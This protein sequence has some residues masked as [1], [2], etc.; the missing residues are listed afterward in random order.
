MN[1]TGRN[2]NFGI[3][4]GNYNFTSKGR[5]LN[6]VRLSPNYSMTCGDHGVDTSRKLPFLKLY[7]Q[8]SKF[9]FKIFYSCTYC[10]AKES[11]EPQCQ[12]N[13]E[14]DSVSLLRR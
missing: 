10:C 13:C 1:L 5:I 2:N 12:S 11:I 9:Y 8:L 4:D 3:Q 7:Y 6:V 14:F